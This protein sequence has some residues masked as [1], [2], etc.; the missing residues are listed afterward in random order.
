MLKESTL[1]HID[2]DAADLVVRH[3][4]EVFVLSGLLYFGGRDLVIRGKL[5]KVRWPRSSRPCSIRLHPRRQ[6]HSTGLHAGLSHASH[7]SLLDQLSILVFLDR[8][9]LVDNR[10]REHVRVPGDPGPQLGPLLQRMRQSSYR[11]RDGRR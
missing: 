3:A 2:E 9:E 8:L 4:L 6:R 7:C 5:R 10:S 11:L 1:L